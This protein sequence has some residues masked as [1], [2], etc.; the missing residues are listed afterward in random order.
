MKAPDFWHHPHQLLSLLLQPVVALYQWG[1]RLRRQLATPYRAVVPVICV[2]NIVAGG[3]GKT[4]VG[5]SL[6]RMLQQQGFRPVFVTR[7]YGGSAVGPLRVDVTRHDATAVGDEALLLADVAPTW[8]GKNKAATVE[9]AAA[10][11]T[12]II[13]DDGLQNPTVAHDLALLV[14]DSDYGFGNGQLFPAGPMRERLASAMARVQG[15]V[16]I[17]EADGPELKNF[18]HVPVLR[19]NLISQLPLGHHQGDC[20]IAFAGIGRPEK[21]FGKLREMGLTLLATRSFADHHV[22]SRQEL[23]AL[24]NMATSKNAKLITTRKDYVRL[25]PELREGVRVLDISFTAFD[26][27]LLGGL[28]KKTSLPQSR[29]LLEKTTPRLPS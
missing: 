28:M 23:A 13:L 15:V 20:Y 24:Q 1:Y 26:P 16:L 12:H 3:S 14:I 22:F 19:G 10:D 25:P 8:V 21:F 6:A 9:A 11:G 7:G 2:G 27:Q 29:L 4:P 17:G 5:L 18:Q